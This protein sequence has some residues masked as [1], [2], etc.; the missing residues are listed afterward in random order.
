MVFSVIIIIGWLYVTV[1]MAASE[2]TLL[3]GI[4]TFVLY[5]ALPLAILMYL[6]GGK[7]RKARRK[8][9]EAATEADKKL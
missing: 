4:T 5:G 7:A 2:P 8:A 1:L 9:E 3:A 6:M